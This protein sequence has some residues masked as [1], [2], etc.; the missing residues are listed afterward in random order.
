MTTRERF[1]NELGNEIEIKVDGKFR[2]GMVLI[3]IHGPNSSSTNDITLQEARVLCDVLK[4]EL[5]YN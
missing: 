2:N 4:E 5:Y 1:K 3:E